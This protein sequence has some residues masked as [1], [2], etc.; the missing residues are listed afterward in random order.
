MVFLALATPNHVRK[1]FLRETLEMPRPRRRVGSKAFLEGILDHAR[2]AKQHVVLPEGDEPRAI[3]A[4][5]KL[6]DMIP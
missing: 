3:R 1:I 2:A 5:R 4:T 6:L